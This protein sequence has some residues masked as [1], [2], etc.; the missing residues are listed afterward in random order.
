MEGQVKTIMFAFIGD[1]LHYRTSLRQSH[2]YWLMNSNNIKD[3]EY[4]T[5]VMGEM[6]IT[7]TGSC[8]CT[9]F[10]G[11]LGNET[12]LTAEQIAALVSLWDKQFPN[13]P[14]ICILSGQRQNLGDVPVTKVD[15]YDR[16]GI[17]FM[18]YAELWRE[19]D[20]KNAIEGFAEVHREWVLGHS[21]LG[22]MP[23]IYDNQGAR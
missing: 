2:S 20:Y 6:R 7:N 22:K 12:P 11:T 23:I 9:A 13:S 17:H 1:E 16:Y 4:E 10:K 3:H 19:I 8:L 14:C 21:E 5:T 18:D 15:R